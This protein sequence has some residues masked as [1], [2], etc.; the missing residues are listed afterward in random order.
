MGGFKV[1]NWIMGHLIWPSMGPK[2]TGS[3][4]EVNRKWVGSG[5][6]GIYKRRALAPCH[7]YIRFRHGYLNL[8]SWCL[9]IG[10]PMSVNSWKFTLG[11]LCFSQKHIK[12]ASSHHI[13]SAENHIEKWILFVKLIISPSYQ[14]LS[15][16][17]ANKF[18][19]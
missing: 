14:T 15:V 2:W 13:F 17:Y 9:S 7:F 11:K 12:S 6:R 18:I 5:M 1:K 10:V 19:T 16:S 3:E 8:D 4:Q